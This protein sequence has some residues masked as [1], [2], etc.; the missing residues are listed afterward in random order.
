MVNSA[1]RSRNPSYKLY[2]VKHVND[3]NNKEQK[4]D[5][6]LSIAGFKEEKKVR[7]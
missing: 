6:Y 3:S 1:F 4:E 2:Y 7:R 5:E